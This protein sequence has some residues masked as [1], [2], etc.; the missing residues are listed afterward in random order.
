M[1]IT[2][3]TGLPAAIVAAVVN[4]DYDRGRSDYTVTQLIDSPRR[5]RLL[6]DHDDEIEVDAADMLYALWGQ[7]THTVLERANVIDAVEDRLYVEFD[8]VTLGGKF[9]TLALTDQPG[10]GRVLSDYKLVRTWEVINGPKEE[11]HQQLNILGWMARKQGY[12]VDRLEAVMMMRD[13]SPREKRRKGND[14]PPHPII[15]FFIPTWP[16]EK[17]EAFIRER[18][19]LH[20]RAADGAIPECSD[21]ERWYQ[22]TKYALKKE[23][24]KRA[25]RVFSTPEDAMTFAKN[26]QVVEVDESGEETLIDGYII[27]RR[28][29]ENVRCMDY[30]AASEVCSQWA[31]LRS[32][33][34][35]D[36]EGGDE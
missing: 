31:A 35:E 36:G 23:K 4:D 25:W 2:N 7:S 12:R 32:E 20:L 30:C 13:W 19:A 14:Y 28:I 3:E 21:A 18:I 1:R 6:R 11:K 8:G 24:N 16:D 33:Q 34:V 27:E 22:G 9:D 29:G 26:K 17:T 10:Y 15:R 5:V